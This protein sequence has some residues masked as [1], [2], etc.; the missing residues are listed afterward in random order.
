MNNVLLSTTFFGVTISLLTYFFG[1]FLRKKFNYAIVN[2]LLISTILV[3]VFLLVFDVDYATYNQGAQY[4]SVFLTPVTICLA[5][6]LYRQ[7]QVLKKNVVAVI[8]S[9]S[10]GVVAHACTLLALAKLFDLEKI[11]TLSILS[12]SVTTPIAVGI[13]HELKGIEAVTIMGVMVAGIMGAVLGPIVCKLFR[14]KEP[15]AQGLGIGSASHAVG[16]SKALEMGEIQGAMS[17]L[18]IVVTAILT[19]I[20][21]PIVARYV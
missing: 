8:V 18:A 11:L 7:L 3:I 9:I 20:V 15:V 17:S 21:V 16:T 4:L 1:M 2:P 5:V 6:P 12:K 13:S 10:C 14:I 19:V